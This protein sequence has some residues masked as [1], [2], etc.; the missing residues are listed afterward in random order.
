MKIVIAG[1]GK[2]GAALTEQLCLE[3]HDVVVIDPD[4]DRMDRMANSLDVMCIS[5]DAKSTEVLKNAGIADAD[6]LLAMTADDEE[7]LMICLVAR[8]MGASNTIARVRNPVY[9]TSISVI[10]DELGL[11]MT[12]N[13]DYE[14][15]SEMFRSLRFKSAG[16][17]ESF[18][19][20]KT[21]ILTCF[22]KEG[23]PICN[24]QIKDIYDHIKV[25]IFVCAIKRDEKVFIPNGST[26]I[27][28]NDTLSFVASDEE[29]NAFFKK[30]NYDTGKI[31][32]LTIIGGG[33]LGYYLGKMALRAGI[34]LKLIDKDI[35]KCKS[36][37]MELKGAEVICGDGMDTGLLTE[38][39]I[40]SSQAVACLTGNDATNTLIGM[41]ISKNSERCKVIAKI[42][43]SDFEDMLFNLGYG[44]VYNSKYIAVDRIL[45]Y[46]RAMGNAIEGE[47]QSLS[48][49]IDN[50]VEVLEFIVHEDSPHI[51]ERLADITFKKNLLIA[52][53]RRNGRTFVPGGEDVFKPGDTLLVVT[54]TYGISKFSE[55]FE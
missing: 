41:Y 28:A 25:R 30:L 16:Q 53:I 39:N 15:A 26:E 37:K 27:K 24:V 2:V 3:K 12:I 21:E 23:T 36:L 31:T 4:E 35:N 34:P 55:I 13:P 11:S 14:A 49:V 54:T 43:K 8:K 42:K 20:G 18:A 10:K 51:R 40:L 6:I 38:E 29:A 7:N 9:E 46:V 1:C 47:F 32:D 52:S 33:K 44:S 19:K 22:V 45:R 17:V 50:K 48:H 5:G